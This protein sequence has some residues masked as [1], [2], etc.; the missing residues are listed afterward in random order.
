MIRFFYIATL[1]LL[2]YGLFS[3]ELTAQKVSEK[4]LQN[5]FDK[6]KELYN[7]GNNKSD[8]LALLQFHKIL[9]SKNANIP[10]LI[11]TYKLIGRIYY[12]KNNFDSTIFFEKKS[13]FL[14]KKQESI[15]YNLLALNYKS[16]GET[17]WRK[18]N[19]DSAFYY[20]N[21]G[22]KITEE[23]DLKENLAYISTS[24]GLI[25]YHYGNYKLAIN[26][27]NKALEIFEED[28]KKFID[29]IVSCRSNIASS[30]SML[31]DKTSGLRIQRQLVDDIIKQKG[32]NTESEAIV[33]Q[34]I[35]LDCH[36]EGLYETAIVEFQKAK[37]I[38][39]K[40]P[41]ISENNY[42]IKLYKAMGN[43]YRE[44][45][46]Y[47]EASK[48][49]ELAIELLSKKG[50]EEKILLANVLFEKAELL[51]R[52]EEF[53]KGLELFQKSILLLVPKFKD[54]S[55]FANPDGEAALSE[56]QLFDAL[57]KKANALF[58]AYNSNKDIQYLKGSVDT[59][60]SAINLA[61]KVRRSLNSDESQIIFNSNIYPIYEEAVEAS[62][63]LF[64][65]TEDPKYFEIALNCTG[66]SKAAVLAD[67]LRNTEIKQF[68][69]IPQELLAQ[70][71]RVKRR[72]AWLNN[73]LISAPSH[74]LSELQAM[75][76]DEEIALSRVLTD[77][78]KYPRYYTLKYDN[79]E[80]SLEEI[81][82]SLPDDN[83]GYIEYFL[84][85][86]NLYTFLVSE[87]DIF[88]SKLAISPLFEDRLKEFKKLL[89]QYQEGERFEGLELSNYLFEQLLEPATSILRGLNRL[90]IVRDQGLNYIP[91][92]TLSLSDDSPD[93]L[94][95][96]FSI[97]YAPSSRVFIR[98]M[99]NPI[100]VKDINVLAYA[101]YSHFRQ[102]ADSRRRGLYRL[103]ASEKEVNSIG[104]TILKD[105][106]ATKDHF[107][108]R[109][110][111]YS[112]IHLATHARAD[113]QKPGD[114]YIA[115]YPENLNDDTNYNMY[116]RELYELSLDSVALLVLS[117]C[118]TG[119]G[120]LLKGEGV[121][122]I[123]R[124]IN[125]AGCNNVMMTLW[126]ADDK[127]SADI[128]IRF[129]DYLKKGI[130][131]DIALQKAKL[132][133]LDSDISREYKTPFYWANF[134]LIGSHYPVLEKQ[135]INWETIFYAIGSSI[136]LIIVT[137][138]IL[139]HYRISKEK[140]EH[141]GYLDED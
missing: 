136:I 37:E 101:P 129:Y 21:Q 83:T 116:T 99:Q 49:Y 102:T 27:Y 138:G 127:S 5:W 107:R 47:K 6:G 77:F 111:N 26:Y 25:Y 104:T 35:A 16:L 118:E 89:Y 61:E 42:L 96:R 132:D 15:D 73:Q 57:K 93:Y 51:I 92:E 59:Y 22:F 72:L 13:L 117:A 9:S 31:G 52:Q 48:N 23:K 126:Q 44:L 113:D 19:Y 95:K 70:E 115:F 43:T 62:V 1:F 53:K 103:I 112:M 84:G 108:T 76:R 124:G 109:A 60:L 12:F 80:V 18:E 135:P 10:L 38:Y 131:K 75:I 91:F 79:S 120:P 50:S 81:R 54:T 98:T 90:I 137:L 65:Q 29:Y 110:H 106:E 7:K 2:A 45:R 8:S 34:N 63:V 114:S 119:D 4:R 85:E 69:T 86:K 24:L 78:E 128:A 40:I 88:C 105:Y 30:Y 56:I 125:Y 121:M 123:A 97:A 140:R 133:Y 67:N 122:S 74:K 36:S 58:L 66:K 32:N 141:L 46:D 39:D 3:F 130:A 87:D 20:L 64:Y 17:Y 55:F 14:R 11:E 82:N 134:V 71:K 94:L 41:A 139:R 100:Y 28:Y 33:R 68:G